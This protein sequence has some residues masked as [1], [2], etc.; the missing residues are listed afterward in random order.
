MQRI[1]KTQAEAT[2]KAHGSGNQTQLQAHAETHTDKKIKNK[3]KFSAPYFLLQDTFPLD[4]SQAFSLTDTRKTTQH[5]YTNILELIIKLEIHNNE[6]CLLLLIWDK[7][8][9][10]NQRT[11]DIFI[12]K[13]ILHCCHC[14]L[15]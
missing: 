15:T 5:L 12:Q 13:Q 11:Q 10:I 7:V 2:L 8:P 6:D 1:L 3:K 4:T 9:V 14:L